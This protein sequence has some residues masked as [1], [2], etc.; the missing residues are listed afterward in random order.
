MLTT[1]A[2]TLIPLA[3][4]SIAIA[5]V[6]DVMAPYIKILHYENMPIQ[7]YWKFSHQKMKIFR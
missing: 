2:F 5:F 4:S 1:H 6:M 3:A 7:M